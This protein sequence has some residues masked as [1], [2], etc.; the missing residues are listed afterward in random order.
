MAL[1]RR[2]GGP[3]ERPTMWPRFDDALV[4]GG[5]CGEHGGMEER[6]VVDVAGLAEWL[7]A[8]AQDRGLIDDAID[9]GHRLGGRGKELPPL[10]ER[11][12]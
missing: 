5:I 6:R 9:D 7:P 3:I 11:E 10:P 1:H 12:V 4:G 8:E 2:E